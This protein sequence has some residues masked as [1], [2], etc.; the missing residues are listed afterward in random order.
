MKPGFVK[1]QSGHVSMETAFC[2]VTEKVMHS[3]C[4]DRLFLNESYCQTECMCPY[5]T[6]HNHSTDP[7][8]VTGLQSMAVVFAY[9]TVL[10]VTVHEV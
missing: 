9:M 5:H 7:R 10:A 1:P 8:L 2:Y 4:I 3:K 6:L